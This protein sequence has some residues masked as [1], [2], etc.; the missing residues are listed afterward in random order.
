MHVLY[1]LSSTTLSFL[2]PSHLTL[3]LP[4]GRACFALTY[5]GYICPLLPPSIIYFRVPLIGWLAEKVYIFRCISCFYESNERL[6]VSLFYFAP[7]RACRSRV[8]ESGTSLMTLPEISRGT[9]L[10]SLPDVSSRS[11]CSC[12]Y[13]PSP[14]YRPHFLA[15]ALHSIRLEH[16][17]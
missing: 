5:C 6:S 8:S 3:L 12:S 16:E 14:N 10:S 4:I 13:Q 11:S 17:L 9:T 15:F 7:G 1:N 2:I